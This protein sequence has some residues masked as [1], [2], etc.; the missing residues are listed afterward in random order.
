MSA[1]SAIVLAM[2]AV[3][4]AADERPAWL[5]EAI[6]IG[7]TRE[8]LPPYTAPEIAVEYTTP[9]RRVAR[10][11]NKAFRAGR[12]LR[13]AD[14]DPRAWAPELRVLAGPLPVGAAPDALATPKAVRLV[15]GAGEI[16]ASRTDR[17]TSTHSVSAAGGPPRK[18]S[19]R[20]LRAVFEVPGAG[21]YNATLEITYAFT[22]E[23]REQ[24]IV[25][26]VALD[27]RRTRW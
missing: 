4:A 1:R 9:F 23:G 25:K 20:D 2:L 15:L 19:G 18:V 27:F 7:S 17:G 24:E 21:L 26:R 13:P 16:A 10:A 14:V 22:G 6:A 8:A 11:A 3:A 12:T 5:A